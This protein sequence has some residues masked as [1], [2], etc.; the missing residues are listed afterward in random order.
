MRI[1]KAVLVLFAI[2]F[3]QISCYAPQREIPLV[4]P[5]A[6]YAEIPSP[7]KRGEINYFLVDAEPGVICHAGIGYYNYKGVWEF[8]DLP[9]IES[10]EA[11]NCKWEWEVPEDA[12]DGFAEF[13]GYLEQGDYERNIFPTTFCI[14]ICE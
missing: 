9:T 1:P 2:L 14:E 10:Q 4:R 8:V 7:V 11:G 13:R 12:R 5:T 3:A 6:I